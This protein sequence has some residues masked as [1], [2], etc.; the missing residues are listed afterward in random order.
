MADPGF[1]PVGGANSQKPIILSIFCQKLH[2]NDR[3]WTRGGGGARVP[4]APLRSANTDWLSILENASMNSGRMHTEHIS[5]YLGGGGGGGGYTLL[6]TPGP[7]CFPPPT[8]PHPPL[9]PS[10]CWNTHPSHSNGGE[11]MG[12][13]TREFPVHR[14]PSCAQTDITEN[15][16]FPQTMLPKMI[17]KS[18][19]WPSSYYKILI[20]PHQSLKTGGR[21]ASYW[22][23]FL[24]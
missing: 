1:S 20:F 16:T 19:D 13:A 3:I 5:G 6:Y 4:G 15:I 7:H 17:N 9:F 21:Y 24:F 10:A 22:N 11:G 12:R 2:E 8:H 14:E 23:A 18:A